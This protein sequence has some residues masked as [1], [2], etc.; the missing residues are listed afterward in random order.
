MDEKIHMLKDL[1]IECYNMSVDLEKED[2]RMATY[3]SILASGMK[4]ALVTLEVKDY[5]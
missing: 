4:I 1:Y 5:D 3:Y 2:P